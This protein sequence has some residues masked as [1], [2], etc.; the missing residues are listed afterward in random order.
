MLTGLGTV[1][2]A[3]LVVLFFGRWG[4]WIAGLIVLEILDAISKWMLHRRNVVGGMVTLLTK[5]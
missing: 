5:T 2:G 1:L 4:V 3:G